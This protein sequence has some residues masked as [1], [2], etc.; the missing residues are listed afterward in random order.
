MNDEPTLLDRTPAGVDPTTGELLTPGIPVDLDDGE[1]DPR[2][3]RQRLGTVEEE[4]KRLANDLQLAERDLRALRRREEDLKRQ[5]D[6]QRQ[7]APEAQVVK[8]I[9]RRW[10][11]RTGRNPKRTKLGKKRTD[12][13]LARLREGIDPQILFRA[14]D[15][16]ALAATTSSPETQRLALLAV[17]KRAVDMVDPPE[18]EELRAMYAE[19]M[20]KLVV[21]DDLELAL[22][23]EVNV[24]R[25]AAIADRVAPLSVE[26]ESL[27]LESA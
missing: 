21:Y 4:R 18:A 11:N 22:R 10:V 15:G 14:V 19:Q 9:Y 20:K 5:L 12:V 6:E 1:Q 26:G 24:E 27:G 3:L 8:A 23:N 16:I 13:V 17:M 25:F 7:D 2:Y